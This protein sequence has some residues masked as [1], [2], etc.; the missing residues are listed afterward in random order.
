MA[1]DK[2]IMNTFSLGKLLYA[3]HKLRD[4]FWQLHLRNRDFRAGWNVHNT[5]AKPKIMQHVRDVLILRARKHI[6]VDTHPAQ[7]MRQVAHIDIH[8]TGVFTTQGGQRASVVG[9]HGY[10]HNNEYNRKGQ[11]LHDNKKHWYNPA[12]RTLAT[13]AQSVEQ[14]FRK[15][16]VKSSNLFG[17]SIL[18]I[19]EFYIVPGNR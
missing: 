7:F 15:R 1:V 3:L 12:A 19:S 10:F 9:K 6:H 14:T 8:P 4:V 11:N 13:I 17:G 16:Q 2:I 18:A 5:V